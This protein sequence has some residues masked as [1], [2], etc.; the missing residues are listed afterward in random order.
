MEEQNERDDRRAHALIEYEKW[1]KHKN[2]LGRIRVGLELDFR[3][4]VK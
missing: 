4:G 3:F 2:R 1:K